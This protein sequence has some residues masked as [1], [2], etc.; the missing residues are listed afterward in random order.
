MF[1]R[2]KSL[3]LSAAATTAGQD[4]TGTVQVWCRAATQSGLTDPGVP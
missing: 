4:S 1:S 2:R 3:G